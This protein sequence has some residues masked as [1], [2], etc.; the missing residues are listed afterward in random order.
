MTMA[1]PGTIS[2][3]EMSVLSAISIWASKFIVNFNV[4][5]RPNRGHRRP[6]T[7]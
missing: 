6:A 3:S 2:V 1:S 4:T 5:Y 7:Y